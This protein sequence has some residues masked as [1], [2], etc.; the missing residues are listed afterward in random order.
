M[1]FKVKQITREARQQG[2]GKWI[3]MDYEFALKMGFTLDDYEVIYEG[4]IITSLENVNIN[5]ILENL[6]MKFNTMRP[7]GYKGHSLSVSDIIEIDGSNYY[8]DNT[9]WIKIV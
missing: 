5:E 7:E 9:E 1:H 3:F 4:N 2:K 6:F 8:C